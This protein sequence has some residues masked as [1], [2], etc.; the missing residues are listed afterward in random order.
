MAVSMALISGCH[1]S[2]SLFAAFLLPSSSLV[3]GRCGVVWRGE[4]QC[5]ELRG[6]GR[7]GVALGNRRGNR[8]G[9]GGG[10]GKGGEGVQ[11]AMPY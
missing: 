3:L 4:V 7:R 1:S 10:G 6:G 11:Q 8:A 2:M 5:G 9:R